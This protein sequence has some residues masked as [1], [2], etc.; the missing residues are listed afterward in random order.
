MDPRSTEPQVRLISR[1]SQLLFKPANVR[2]TYSYVCTA[3]RD[4]YRAAERNRKNK[5]PTSLLIT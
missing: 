3:Y 1:Q 5:N 4:T 2:S